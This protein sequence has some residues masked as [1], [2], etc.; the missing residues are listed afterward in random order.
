MQDD[1]R[2]RVTVLEQQVIDLQQQLADE[3]SKRA[4]E[5]NRYSEAEAKAQNTIDE[6][7]VQLTAA[8]LVISSQQLSSELSG[9]GWFWFQ[10]FQELVQESVAL[11]QRVSSQPCAY[12]S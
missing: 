4:E 12:G 1:E 8:D 6:L 3:K 2:R 5:S 10:V 11:L 9:A 7:S